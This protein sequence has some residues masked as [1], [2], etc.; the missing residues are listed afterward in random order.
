MNGNFYACMGSSRTN[1]IY[2]TQMRE[3]DVLNKHIRANGMV[4]AMLEQEQKLLKN[5][6]FDHLVQKTKKWLINDPKWMGNIV[7]DQYHLFWY[8]IHEQ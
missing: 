5:A 3:K 1:H 2:N 4:F 6:L 8:A 7:N